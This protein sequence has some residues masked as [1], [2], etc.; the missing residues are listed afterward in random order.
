MTE[1]L[2]DRAAHGAGNVTFEITPKGVPMVYVRDARY[3]RDGELLVDQ[4][5]DRSGNRCAVMTRRVGDVGIEV[6]LGQRMEIKSAGVLSVN[7]RASPHAPPCPKVRPQRAPAMTA[8]A[9]RAVRPS[10]ADD[11]AAQLYEPSLRRLAQRRVGKAVHDRYGAR[12]GTPRAFSSE[13]RACHRAER[14]A[15]MVMSDGS[16]VVLSTPGRR[17]WHVVDDLDEHAAGAACRVVDRLALL[18]VEEVHEHL[19]D[20]ARRVELAGLLVGEVGK[21]LD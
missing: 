10:G 21:L 6:G 3:F 11:A 16:R 13:H 2:G 19:H 14:R 1:R 4:Q 20:R 17:Y 7:L 9:A 18:R 15:R 12:R 8:L 5:L